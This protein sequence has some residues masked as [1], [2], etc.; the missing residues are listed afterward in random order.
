MVNVATPAALLVAEAG[1]TLSGAGVPRVVLM[2]TILPGTAAL[3]ASLSVTVMVIG[4]VP[5]LGAGEPV[6]T[7]VELVALTGLPT[8]LN[9]IETEPLTSTPSLGTCAVKLTVPGV[10]DLSV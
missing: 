5:S 2:D 10:V 8:G 7:T 1:V 9:V 6:A 4:V 3:A